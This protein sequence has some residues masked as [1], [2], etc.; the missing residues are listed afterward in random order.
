MQHQLGSSEGLLGLQKDGG[1]PLPPPPGYG[2]GKRQEA[3]EPVQ[4]P[5]RGRL[6]CFP[7]VR[8]CTNVFCQPFNRFSEP[9]EIP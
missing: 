9:F 1:E 7:V 4:R 8:M 2:Y 5:P 3:E 6:S